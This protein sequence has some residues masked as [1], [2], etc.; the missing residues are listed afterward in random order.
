MNKQRNVLLPGAGA[1]I[2]WKGP[3]T[4]EITDLVRNSG[5]RTTDNDL[6]SVEEFQTSH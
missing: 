6:C 4:S 3:L 1:V 2:D 5:F